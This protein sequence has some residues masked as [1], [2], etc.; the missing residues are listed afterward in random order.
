VWTIFLARQT[1][2]CQFFKGDNALNKYFMTCGIFSNELNPFLIYDIQLHCI[3]DLTIILS[4]CKNNFFKYFEQYYKHFLKM[5]K[6]F[7]LKNLL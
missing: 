4:A 7:L 3:V 2:C 6:C 1:L 5:Y